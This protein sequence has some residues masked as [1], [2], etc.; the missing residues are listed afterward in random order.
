LKSVKHSTMD[1][2]LKGI[3]GCFG[4]QQRYPTDT[5]RRGKKIYAPPDSSWLMRRTLRNVAVKDSGGGS[6]AGGGSCGDVS[7]GR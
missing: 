6:G 3:H 7:V 4:Y 2:C 1:G 5:E